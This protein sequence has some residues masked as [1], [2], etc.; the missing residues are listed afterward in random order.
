MSLPE[1][2]FVVVGSGP[3]GL[4]AACTLAEQG[5]RV[6]VLE[7][8]P[9]HPGGAVWSE[10]ATRP[11]F[12]HDV[13]AAFMSFGKLSPAFRHLGLERRGVVWRHLDFESCHPAPDGS[14]ASISRDP[15]TNARHFG[16]PRDGEVW[17]DLCE[18][19]RRIEPQLLDGLLQPFP[20]VGPALRLLPFDLPR[21]TRILMSSGRRLARRLFESEAARRVIPGLALHADVGPDDTFGAGLGYVLGVVASTGG[22]PVPE[23]GAKRITLALLDFLEA[24]GGRLQLGQRVERIVVS[25]GRARA[26]RTASGDEIA[27]SHGVLADTAAPSLF[28]DLVERKHL[29]GRVVRAMQRF[30]QGWGTF[31]M[32]WALS[33]PVPWSA[34]PARRSLVVHAADSLDDMSRFTREVRAGELPQHPYLVIGQQSL[35]D[36]GRA[37][38]GGQTLWAYTRVPSRVAGG[39]AAA[40]ESFADR[41][42]ARI[43]GLAPGFRERIL[44]R[45]IVDPGDF[46]AMNANLVGGDHGGGSNAWKRQLIFRPVFPW[47][48]YATP[49][50]GLYLCSSYTHPGGG[51]HGMCGYNAARVA[52]RRGYPTG[53]EGRGKGDAHG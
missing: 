49:V 15:E 7:A 47:F 21:L 29:P 36:P 20:S 8:H 46:E 51:V 53:P 38:A 22:F 45:R 16:S 18:R 52:L 43:E 12:L 3:N 26:V 14:H 32:D 24:H 19:H 50:G 39:W 31:K 6:L 28:L 48:R 4:V 9:G 2:D 1:V 44:E 27:C 10:E 40:R 34:E 30:P 33:G 42:E 37:P 25:E 11:G 41:V 17:R 13:G 5:C 23:G 35:A